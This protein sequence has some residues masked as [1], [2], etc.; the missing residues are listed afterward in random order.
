[1]KHALPIVLFSLILSHYFI[2]I[3]SGKHTDVPPFPFEKVRQKFQFQSLLTVPEVISSLENVTVECDK[4]T[5]MELFHTG[6]GKP[7]KIE[8]FDQAQG[9]ATMQVSTFQ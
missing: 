4:V 1:M 6:T 2:F 7:L 9:Q 5:M 3:L 8:E